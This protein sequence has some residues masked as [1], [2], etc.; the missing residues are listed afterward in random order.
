MADY[1]CDGDDF[2]VATDWQTLAGADAGE[3]PGENQADNIF[4]TSRMA[5]ALSANVDQSAN[6]NGIENMTVERGA[7]YAIGTA[8]APL[9]LKLA[10]TPELVFNN[11][12]S[13]CTVHLVTKTVGVTKCTVNRTGSSADALHLVYDDVACTLM[14][15]FGGNITLDE[16][17]NQLDNLGVVTLNVLTGAAGQSPTLTLWAPVTTVLNIYSG[18]VF[19]MAGTLT[20]VNMYG[21][22][23]YAT[24]STRARTL[25]NLDYYG[26]ILDLR[27]GIADRIT[28][29]NAVAIKGEPGG[30]I[31]FDVGQTIS[32][33]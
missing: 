2:E 24:R 14:D 21:G 26:G 1:Y 28:V 6:P 25:T 29:S 3:Y 16:Y 7:A 15:I 31:F 9:T 22:A 23:L 19:W 12:K 8:A 20:K 4:F 18:T 17:L 11:D 5:A 32:F 30:S 13:G 27:C 10:T 33:T